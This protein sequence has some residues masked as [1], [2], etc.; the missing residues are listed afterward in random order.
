[1]LGRDGGHHART[2]LGQYQN[3]RTSVDGL[4]VSHLGGHVPVVSQRCSCGMGIDSAQ[5]LVAK[6]FLA[7]ATLMRA[8]PPKPIK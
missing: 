6:S 5:G 7:H 4:A 8:M 2:P 3:L 1:M